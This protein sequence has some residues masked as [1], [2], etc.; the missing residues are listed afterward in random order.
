MNRIRG[1]F[2]EQASRHSALG[3]WVLAGA[4]FLA[5]LRGAQDVQFVVS[6]WDAAFDWILLAGWIPAVGF[7]L[8]W[9][10]M[11]QSDVTTAEEPTRTQETPD[12]VALVQFTDAWFFPAWDAAMTVVI[13]VRGHIERAEGERT[14]A[15]FQLG[16]IDESVARWRLLEEKVHQDQGDLPLDELLSN[17]YEKYEHLVRWIVQGGETNGFNFGDNRHVA[18]WTRVDEK[19]CDRL[20]DLVALPELRASRIKRRIEELEAGGVPK[21]MRERLRVA[22]P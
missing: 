7:M 21:A 22:A 11:G 19:M 1:Y 18:D 10:W 16:V 13:D 4:I 3:P 20:R 8:F 15:L 5:V 14:K 12:P 17:A 9:R 6:I 2:E